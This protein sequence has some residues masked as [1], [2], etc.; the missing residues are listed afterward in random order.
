MTGSLYIDGI[1]IF[2]QYKVAINE[3]GYNGLI[4]AADLKGIE[5]ID[6]PEE[7]GIEADLSN[8]VLD[9]KEFDIVFGNVNNTLTE[10]FLAF[11]SN[12][13]YHDFDLRSI[14][15]KRKLRLISQPN[16]ETILY[17]ESFSLRFADDFPLKNYNYLSPIRTTVVQSGYNIDNKPLSD[18]GVM[19]L[20]GSDDEIMKIPDVKKNLTQDYMSSSGVLYD[21]FWVK[22]QHKDVALKCLLVAPNLVIFWRNYNALIYDLIRPSERH[23]Y[24]EGFNDIFPCFYKSCRVNNFSLIGAQVWCDF[25]LTLTF[26]NFRPKHNYYVWA[27]EDKRII[28]TEDNINAIIR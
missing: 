12:V 20:D 24:V 11:L 28:K 18:Y 22:Y 9:K 27:S 4:S 21:N 19:I 10:D 15:C 8:P 7:N 3:G 5:Y 13:P 23:L 25:T 2:S 14:G 1:D 26:L 6:W 16:K 17:A